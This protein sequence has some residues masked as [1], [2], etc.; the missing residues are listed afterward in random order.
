M[1]P[2][3]VF[4][5]IAFASTVA[6][7]AWHPRPPSPEMSTREEDGFQVRITRHAEPNRFE[8]LPVPS[9]KNPDPTR[10]TQ[11]RSYVGSRL[12]AGDEAMLAQ[13]QGRLLLTPGEGSGFGELAS[14]CTSGDPFCGLAAAALTDDAGLT[15]DELSFFAEG[16]LACDPAAFV[17]LRTDLRLPLEVRLKAWRGFG[18]GGMWS[19]EL[20][21]AVDE[22]LSLSDGGS[23]TIHAWQ[24]AALIRSVRSDSPELLDASV[25]L[26]EADDHFAT[27]LTGSA[28]VRVRALACARVDCPDEWDSGIDPN[29][30]LAACA[31]RLDESGDCLDRLAVLD[32]PMARMV[33]MRLKSNSSWSSALRAFETRE[34]FET[35]ARSVSAHALVDGG[36]HPGS[37][38]GE[39][40]DE[41]SVDLYRH[42]GLGHDELA[43]SWAR[44]APELEG[45]YFIEEAEV[46]GGVRLSG[47]RGD[48][49][50][51]IG[52]RRENKTLDA[53]V[54]I[55]LLNVMAGER[56]STRR[57]FHSK[58]NSMRTVQLADPAL[59]SKLQERGLIVLE[60]PDEARKEDWD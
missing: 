35:F 55:A 47:R 25:R 33:A 10:F 53:R 15:V 17:E 19:P 60:D 42:E 36:Y 45:F 27:M 1:R 43:A 57:F 16:L 22:F 23:K 7:F 31:L 51:A 56:G 48:D 2:Q 34:A 8:N 50:F 3:Y 32:W 46:D 20:G 11:P 39:L 26:M 12:C 29:E 13:V 21:A 38:L 58:L 44:Q 52:V 30:D 14:R 24:V 40:D 18:D 37:L 6:V 9:L 49:L 54:A 28:S 4:S 5:F 59:I 41:T